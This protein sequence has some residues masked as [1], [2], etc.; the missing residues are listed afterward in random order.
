MTRD[1]FAVGPGPLPI[2]CWSSHLLRS[3]PP[4]M[5]SVRKGLYAVAYTDSDGQPHLLDAHH[6]GTREEAQRQA[7]WASVPD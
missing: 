7:S 5:N 6:Y 4:P 3:G 2:R 1:Y